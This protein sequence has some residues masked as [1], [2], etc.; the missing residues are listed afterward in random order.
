MTWQYS[1]APNKM[2]DF[3]NELQEMQSPI[4]TRNQITPVLDEIEEEFMDAFDYYRHNDF[5]KEFK[6]Y[7]NY[8]QD[9][10]Q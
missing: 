3:Y 1:F 2:M 10:L 6:N 7:K 5:F 9:A 4:A 8:Y